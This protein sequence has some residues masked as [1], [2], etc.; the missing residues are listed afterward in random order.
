MHRNPSYSI[1][2][3][4]TPLVVHTNVR[5]DICGVSPITGP[6]YKCVNCPNF[7]MCASK[8]RSHLKDDFVGS[9]YYEVYRPHS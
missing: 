2:P 4:P 3:L 6:R 8:S 9:N 1:Q 7:D 5:C